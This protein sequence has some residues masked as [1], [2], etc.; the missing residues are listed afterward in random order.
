MPI[1]PV[2]AIVDACGS[3]RVVARS[4]RL[5]HARG[6]RAGIIGKGELV[7]G[8]DR[9]HVSLDPAAELGSGHTRFVE[10]AD[11]FRNA[12]EIGSLGCRH[13]INGIAESARAMSNT[14]R[15]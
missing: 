5:A 13:Q 6:S 10:L 9:T 14:A 3:H 15:S 7:A 12:H 1:E 11:D 4:R 2:S 8:A